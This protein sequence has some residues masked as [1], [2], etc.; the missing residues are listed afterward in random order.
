[1]KI[2]PCVLMLAL[3]LVGCD[4]KPDT[5]RT[6]AFFASWLKEHGETNVVVDSAGVG[7]AG[8]ETRMS[9]SLFGTQKAGNGLSAEVEFKIRLPTGGPIIEYVAG[10]GDTREK[11]MDQAMENFVLTT[12]HVIYK[13]FMNPADE[14]QRVKSVVIDGK[15]RELFAGN[16]I[17]FGEQTGGEIDLGSMSA[18]IQDLV[19]A[20]SLDSGPHWIKIVYSQNHRKPMVVA[21]TLDNNDA[22]EMTSAVQ[23]LKWPERDQ[24]YMVKQFIVIK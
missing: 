2:G 13:A 22:T 11:A 6:D 19:V 23:N 20:S 12:A 17:Q 21:A 14:Y 7:L 10:A 4:K 15:S 16:M 5:T 1:M 24:F 18:Q 3:L 8:N 9:A